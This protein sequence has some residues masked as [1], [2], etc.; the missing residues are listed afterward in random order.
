M[1]PGGNHFIQIVYD[2]KPVDLSA[3]GGPTSGWLYDGCFQEVNMTT[4]DVLFSWCASDHFPLDETH[5]YLDVPGQV[6]FTERIAG[7]GT[8]DKPWDFIHINAVDK[9][10]H[11]NYIVSARHFS[12]ILQVAGLNTSTPG[13][14]MWQLGG[15][16]NHFEFEGNFT[17][18]RQH[19]A[20][21]LYSDG[22][23]TLLSLFNNGFNVRNAAALE[24][25]SSSGQI[26]RLD[27]ESGSAKLIRNF[28]HPEHDQGWQ[29]A[30]AIAEGSMDFQRGSHGGAVIGW[31]SLPDV[32]EFAA[33]GSLLFHASVA[34]HTGRTY[35]AWKKPW[36][37]KPHWPPALLAF[38]KE[39]SG[40]S[41]GDSSLVAYASWNGA[42]EVHAWRFS[43]SLVSRH[44]PWF[45]AGIF[46]KQGFETEVNLSQNRAVRAFRFAPYVRVE[47]LD[48]EGNVLGK[49]TAE[50]FVPLPE[51][52]CDAYGCAGRSFTYDPSLSIAGSCPVIRRA[53]IPAAALLALALVCLSVVSWFTPGLRKHGMRALG[54]LRRGVP[55]TRLASSASTAQEWQG[56][57]ARVAYPK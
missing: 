53:V 18:A 28:V 17:F 31:G 50:T 24:G 10:P 43:V 40:N 13:E 22:Q 6:N 30:V 52:D 12:A 15:K 39:C 3:Y 46:A 44:G 37:G 7:T 4:G 16:S 45:G 14:I 21:Y 55:Y 36:I 27:E 47:A 33:D 20:R 48:E 56:A 35:R 38:S 49:T 32:S 23:R 5:L 2:L 42:T 41:D 9:T 51:L 25:L 26:I 11:G 34:N 8:F 1:L 29:D 54:W 57:S 19:H